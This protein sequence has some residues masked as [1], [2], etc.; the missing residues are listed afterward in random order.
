MKKLKQKILYTLIGTSGGLAGL[1]P[2]ARCSGHCVTC[3]GCAGIGLGIVLAL[4]GGMIK[5]AKKRSD[6]N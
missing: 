3:I 6:I 2:F 5:G 4:F 1:L